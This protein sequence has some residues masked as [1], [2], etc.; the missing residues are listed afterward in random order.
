RR[1]EELERAVADYLA[2]A[3]VNRE[4][5]AEGLNL[6]PN[7]TLQAATKKADSDGA[8]DLRLMETYQWALIPTQLKP[9]APVM[10]DQVRVEGQAGLAERTTRKLVNEAHLYVTFAPTLLRQRLDNELATLLESGDVSVAT[11]WDAF[12]RYLYL[13][14]LRDMQVLLTCVAIVGANSVWATDG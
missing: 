9:T 7:Q 1:L 5:G 4:A 14:R 6:D 2:W 10:W 11:L 3:S 13:P 12:A 8:V